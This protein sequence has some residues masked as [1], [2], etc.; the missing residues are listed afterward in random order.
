MRDVRKAEEEEKWWEKAANW[1][2][3]KMTAGVVQQYKN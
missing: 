2:Q 3:W 1:E